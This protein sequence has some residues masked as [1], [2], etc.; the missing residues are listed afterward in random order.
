MKTGVSLLLL[1]L[2]LGVLFVVAG[3]SE[4]GRAVP[5]ERF[6]TAE[7]VTPPLTRDAVRVPG[8]EVQLL[9]LLIAIGGPALLIVRGG[10]ARAIGAVLAVLH[11]LAWLAFLDAA[12]RPAAL[13]WSGWPLATERLLFVV[14]PS[15]LL[16]T[17]AWLCWFD[18]APTIEPEGLDP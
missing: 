3:R 11:G 5:H 2:G 9:A 16:L 1:F 7:S 6:A 18:E 4:M 17:L 14:A 12:A 13:G 8:L 15:P 10:R